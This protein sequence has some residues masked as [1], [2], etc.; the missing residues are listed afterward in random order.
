MRIEFLP[1]GPGLLLE[2]DRRLLVVADLHFG[3]E[4]DMARHGIHIQSN[5]KRRLQRLHACISRTTPDIMVILGDLKHRVPATSR[6]EYREIP[7]VL[8][9]LR[10]QVT[11]RICPGN[12]D[13]G[14][15]RH[16][17]DDELLPVRGA[18]IDDCGFYHGHTFPDPALQ[19]RLVFQGH[20]HPAV[21]IHDEVGYAIRAAPGFLYSR[22]E[23][24]CLFPGSTVE[25][26]S[27][28]LMI[29]PAF[30]ELSGGVDVAG[31]PASGLGPA[32]R[33][34]E[35]ETAEVILNDGSYLGTLDSIAPP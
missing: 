9:A 21:S 8:E 22:I 28:R 12:H 7:R 27:T 17:R 3:I 35:T 25:P 11:L 31:I 6:Q 23:E 24:G 20:C 34:L 14:L 32:T 5:T 4:S 13:V 19:G 26:G 29:V 16:L 18:V 30:N 10:E 15:A 33:C 1:D 2:G